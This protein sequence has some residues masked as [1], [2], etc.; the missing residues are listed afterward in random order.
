MKEGLSMIWANALPTYNPALVGRLV[1]GLFQLALNIAVTSWLLPTVM[2]D[3]GE[4]VEHE[5]PAL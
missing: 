4:V 2:Q 1:L 5:E 3:V